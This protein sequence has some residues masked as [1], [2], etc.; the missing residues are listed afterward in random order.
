[1]RNA[2]GQIFQIG[3]AVGDHSNEGPDQLQQRT[4]SSAQ[5]RHRD[6]VGA[7]ECR[8]TAGVA[9]DVYSAHCRDPNWLACS[10]SLLQQRASG[11]RCYRAPGAH[12]RLGRTAPAPS[13][14]HQVRERRGRSRPAPSPAPPAARRAAGALVEL[15]QAVGDRSPGACLRRDQA[16]PLS[17]PRRERPAHGGTLQLMTA[18]EGEWMERLISVAGSS[19][20]LSISSSADSRRTRRAKR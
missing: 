8:Q 19:F 17:S 1:M 18:R 11:S 16:P 20:L 4:V 9:G 5:G 10:K 6:R 12:P 3:I 15:D 14:H 13:P 2:G 7:Q